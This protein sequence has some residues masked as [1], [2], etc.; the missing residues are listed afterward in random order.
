MKLGP[1]VSVAWLAANLSSPDLVVFDASMYLPTE[2][3]DAKAEFLAAHIPGARFFDI[4]EVADKETSL[5]HMV[6][7]PGRFGAL[8]GAMGVSN[9]SRVVFYDQTGM[10]RAPRGWWL[11]RLFG[12]EDAAVLDGGLPAW[13]KFGGA[14][15]SGE[16]PP[17][18]PAVFTPDFHAER[19]KGIGDMKKLVRGHSV[20]IIDARPR[21]RFEGT[22]PEPREGLQSGHIPGAGNVPASEIT[23]EAGLLLP[24]ASLREAFRAAGADGSRPIVATCGSGVTAAAIALAA[25]VAGL[26]EPAVYDGS[27]AEWGERPETPKI[28]YSVKA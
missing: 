10:T 23:G 2:P 22:A 25:V 12:H 1:V 18:I 3:R 20:A 4:N 8:M 17:P 19:M 13:K 26:P 6:P 7:T 21:G 16:P 14:L 11:F 5:P 28:T 24:P 9:S 15:Q 27:W